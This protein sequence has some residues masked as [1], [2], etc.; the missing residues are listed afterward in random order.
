MTPLD[1]V[2]SY[3]CSQSHQDRQDI[4]T[5]LE[6]RFSGGEPLKIHR[7]LA[8]IESLPLIIT[9]NYDRL[10]ELAFAERH[11]PVNVLTLV[12]RE[13]RYQRELVL[14]QFGANG[15]LVDHEQDVDPDQLARKIDLGGRTLIYKIHGSVM[16]TNDGSLRSRFLIT[17]EDYERAL[18]DLDRFLPPAIL[19]HLDGRKLLFLGYGLRD[20]NVRALLRR[21]LR[22]VSRPSVAVDRCPTKLDREVW[23]ERLTFLPMDIETFIRALENAG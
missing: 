19:E 12:P 21:L 9:T 2:A 17:Q 13:V 4:D 1:A 20:W 8:G 14:L 16:P 3:Y 7:F 10:I 11:K 5:E 15:S 23:K 6:S 22:F 18:L